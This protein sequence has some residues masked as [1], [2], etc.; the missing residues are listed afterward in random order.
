M[1]ANGLSGRC[2]RA[3]SR[4]IASSLVASQARWKPPSPLTATVRPLDQRRA[5]EV[6]RHGALGDHVV[7][8]DVAQHRSAVVARDRLGVVAT[9]GR[10]G[11]LG[12]ALRAHRERRHRGGGS[13][14]RQRSDDREP[15]T[16]VRAGDERVPVATIARVPQFG[17]AV[18]AHRGVGRHER[19]RTGRRST[20]DD[21]ELVGRR[22]RGAPTLHVLDDRQRRGLGEQ[23][24]R[25]GVDLAA[26][27]QTSMN[28]RV[29]SLPTW[30]TR[31]CSWASRYTNGR[32]PTPCTTPETV[33]HSATRS[34]TGMLVTGS[35][36][37]PSPGCC[38][39]R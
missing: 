17:E 18:V 27:P 33:M 24:R 7:V 15:R 30:P 37:I 31:P 16:A 11:V 39:S 35:D 2:L 28:T 6:D 23:A 36:P 14:V 38:R 13:V 25:E 4:P 12:A 3:R 21:H 32:N 22:R 20:L 29:E 1:I 8:G 34:S 9:V 10:I 26:G 19:A 5:G